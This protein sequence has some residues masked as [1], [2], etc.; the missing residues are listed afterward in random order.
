MSQP[1]PRPRICREVGDPL[2]PTLSQPKSQPKSD[3][4]NFG[5]YKD[6]NSG[7]PEFAGERERTELAAG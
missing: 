5:H 3:L 6:P 7:K 2:T 1:A 4:S